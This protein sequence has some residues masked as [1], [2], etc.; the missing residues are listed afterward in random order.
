MA[1]ST[2]LQPEFL[3]S[4]FE[5][6]ICTAALPGEID[7]GELIAK[8]HRECGIT[9]DQTAVDW[10]DIANS[11][12]RLGLT[13]LD[14]MDSATA[15]RIGRAWQRR[16][17]KRMVAAAVHPDGPHPPREI[18]IGGRWQSLQP[19]GWAMLNLMW[20]KQ[21][22]VPISSVMR[23]MWKPNEE[24]VPQTVFNQITRVNQTLTALG[25]NRFLEVRNGFVQWV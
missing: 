5:A 2:S 25:A 14:P 21:N 16:L 18:W 20:K 13:S 15:R 1:M 11:E 24:Q 22:P 10:R 17:T 3:R 19:K 9:G 4:D 7:P 6:A 12:F 23:S 8:L